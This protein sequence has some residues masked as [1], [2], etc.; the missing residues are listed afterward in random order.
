M[1]GITIPFL[2]YQMVKK[3]I[4]K[5]FLQHLDL[6]CVEILV[7]MMKFLLSMKYLTIKDLG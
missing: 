6:T 2:S 5:H 4:Q 1:I 3:F 7:K